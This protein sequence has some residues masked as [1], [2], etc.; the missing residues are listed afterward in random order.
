MRR[1]ELSII[2]K[3]PFIS[4]QWKKRKIWREERRERR[5]TSDFR[6]YDDCLLKNFLDLVFGFLSVKLERTRLSTKLLKDF[7]VNRNEAQRMILCN[8]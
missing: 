8:L 4:L 6:N 3:F 5:I 1:E 2:K 7:G